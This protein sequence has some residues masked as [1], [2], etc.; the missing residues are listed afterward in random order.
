VP[1]EL[2]VDVYNQAGE[3]VRS[4]FGGRAGELPLGINVAGN[5]FF[6]GSG[7]LAL[8]LPGFFVS[9]TATYAS[10]SWD[11]L[12]DAG[13]L[14]QGGTYTIKAQYTDPFGVVTVLT[15]TIEVL[16]QPESDILSIFNS[17]GELVWSRNLSSTASPIVNISL[18]SGNATFAPSYDAAGNAQ[19][20]LWVTGTDST[21][22]TQTYGWNGRNSNGQPVASGSYMMQL[23]EQGAGGSKILVTRSFPILDAY[24]GQSLA[25]SVIAPNPAPAT[26]SSVLVV[27]PDAPNATAKASLYSLDGSLLA[28][29][30][31]LQGSGRI[32][33]DCHNLAGGIY[34]VR[35]EKF[36]ALAPTA[37]LTLKWALLR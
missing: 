32:W 1:F 22:A 18:P 4:I 24:A 12:N 23:S 34:F 15:K 17:A 10:L 13:Q 31:D 35:I 5:A 37:H 7:P 3:K 36:Q 30:W 16:A 14:V 9:R 29:A 21:G 6:E 33:V 11:F 8:G 27:Y 25:G 26:A 19:S 20:L 28:Q 2:S